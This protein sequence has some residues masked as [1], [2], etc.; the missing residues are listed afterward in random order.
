MNRRFVIFAAIATLPLASTAAFGQEETAP[1]VAANVVLVHGAFADGSSWAPV[2]RILQ[3]EG[4]QVVAV[5][6][7]LTSFEEDVAT[8]RRA[9]ARIDG[10]I[11]L[12]GHSY[13]GMVIT[14]AGD[15]PNVAALVY[16][17]A[18]APDVGEDYPALAARFPTPPAGAGIVRADGF[19]QFSE[20]A[21]LSDF[22]GDIP[23]EQARVLF[24]AQGP[25]SDTL[26]SGRTTY[27][28][29]R[30][31]PSYYAISTADRTTSPELQRFVATRMNAEVVELN[32]SHLSP[33][34][35]AEEIAALIIR[36]VNPDQ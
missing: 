13:G 27:A 15:D 23:S 14:E 35:H 18:R 17:A 19:A 11:V 16:V 7:P 24:A 6:N 34:S 36:A 12:V 3:R 30:E 2:I 33:V 20:A 5:Q 28:A 26:F 32:S 31:K 25:I 1:P 4:L 10:P 22:A 9:L 29:W 21:F 8:T